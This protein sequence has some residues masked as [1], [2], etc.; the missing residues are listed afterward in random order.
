[1]ALVGACTV[2]VARR[3]RRLDSLGSVRSLPLLG[4]D[5]ALLALAA[6][7]L[8][9]A[10]SLTVRPS[11]GF[12]VIRLVSQSLFGEGVLLAAVVGF[13]LLRRGAGAAR[14]GRASLALAGVLLGVYYE[15]Y[16]REPEDLQLRHY[17]V[18]ASAGRPRGR[19]RLLHLSDIQ[20]HAVRDYEERVLRQALASKPDLVVMTGDYVQ[21]RHGTSRARATAEFN[22]LLRRLCFDAPLGAYAVRG[23]VDRDWPAVF[24]GTAVWPLGA[25]TVRLT[26]PGGRGLSL[27][28][29]TPGMSHG[30]QPQGS[31]RLVDGT[32]PDDL[33]VVLGHGPDFVM[34]LAGRT[35][36][37]LALAGHTHGGQV[38]LPLIGSPHTR[39]RL[40]R[41]YACGLHVYRGLPLHV[42]AGIG[43]ER[44][45]A[46]QIRF[47]RPPEMSLVEIR[48]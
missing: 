27:V 3:L 41:R 48:Y 38:A 8:A 45:T 25:E 28:G 33:R 29:L 22:A 5:G 26:L 30:R 2:V 37:D 17:V 15:A 1:M 14:A 32:P 19:L 7:G 12:T 46:P 36:V 9:G 39:S 6:T 35:R 24:A 34:A 31:W 40:P 16:H 20:T 44:G 23:D 13:V 42:S 43:M 4:L 21:P 47:L 10:A 18:D 11:S